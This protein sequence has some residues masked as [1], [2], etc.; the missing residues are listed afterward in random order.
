MVGPKG[1][2]VSLE[3]GSGYDKMEDEKERREKLKNICDI[4]VND[5]QYLPKFYAKE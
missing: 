2:S 1:L 4:V 3:L 5:P